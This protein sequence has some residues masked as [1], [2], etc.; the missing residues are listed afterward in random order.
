MIAD[1]KFAKE[2]IQAGG[3]SLKKCYQCAT[4]GVVC[5]Q[6]PDENPFPRK[7]MIWAQWGAKEKLL[8]DA[9]VWL[10]HQCN[11]CSD[12]CPRGAKPGEVLAAIRAKVVEHYTFPSFLSKILRRPAGILVYFAIPIIFTA[13]YLS[14]FAPEIPE[15]KIVLGKFIPH[16][17]VELAGFAVGA[18]VLFVAAISA[19]RFWVAINS[20]VSKV[21][22]YEVKEGGDIRVVKSSARFL[23][24]LFWS[25]I[26]IL[27]HS[28]FQQCNKAKY[29]FYA[30]FMI[31]WGFIVLGVAT[32][33]DIVYLY[34]LGYHE[35]ALPIT[36]PVK[37]LGNLG[38]LLLLV[39]SV[40]AI[41]ARFSDQR[42]GYGTYFDWLFLATIFAVG[43]SGVIIEVLRY[44][45]SVLAYY[46]YLAHL[47]IVFTLLAYAPYTKFAHL[48]YRTLAYVWAKSVGR[49]LKS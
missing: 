30:H 39:G 22:E 18:W 48:I 10:C 7:E 27:K 6:S 11:D 16:T 29:R 23:E 13:L 35:L 40:W 45:G 36:D 34:V 19:Y 5:P 28:K 2:I 42:I 12:Y 43:V 44:S 41:V 25:I 8:S 17:H 1:A 47:V 14:I 24:H 15:G 4:C 31:F 46:A 37:I 32:L 49:E 33:G 9:D 21:Y 26:D 3:K 38:A 20:Q